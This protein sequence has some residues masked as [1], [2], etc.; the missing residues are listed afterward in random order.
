MNLQDTVDFT[1]FKKKPILQSVL[2]ILF[3]FVYPCLL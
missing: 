1:S 3:K 2:I